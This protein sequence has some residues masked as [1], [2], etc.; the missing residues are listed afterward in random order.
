[1]SY[2]KQH[3]LGLAGLALLRNWLI[4]NN[5]VARSILKE[6]QEL[7]R[8]TANKSSATE[9]EVTVF[10]VSRGYKAWAETYDGM[11]NLLIEV[12][13]PAVKSIL[14]KFHPGNALDAA[15]GTGR[16]SEFLNSLGYKVT[17][18]DLSPA[19]L[20][21]ARNTR[22]KQVNFIQGNLTEI[23]LKDSSMDLAVCALALTHLTNTDKAL[24]ELTRVVRRGGHIV[25][26]DIH[27]WLV[28]LGGQAEFLDKTG[29]HGYILNYVHWHSSYFQSFGRLGLKVIQCLEPT[30]KQEHVKLAKIGFDLGEKTIETALKDLPIALIWV[31]ERP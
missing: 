9:K 15:C 24:S 20:S 17:G 21:R 28:A 26:S 2:E 10:D 13:E 27:P 30:M 3:E 14:L 8:K 18:V 4:G 6:I 22:N 11:P 25:L 1:M 5:K 12:E 31:L 7:T 29:K 19:M 23:P 16:Y